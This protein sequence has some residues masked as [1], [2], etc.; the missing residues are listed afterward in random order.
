[1]SRRKKIRERRRALEDGA[2]VTLRYHSFTIA[3][4]RC[5]SGVFRDNASEAAGRARQR[6]PERVSD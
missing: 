2:V 4:R 3:S 1:M 6:E 5:D